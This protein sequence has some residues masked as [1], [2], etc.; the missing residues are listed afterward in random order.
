L[1]L[2]RL[3]PGPLTKRVLGVPWLFAVA[4]SAVGFSLY[5]S[6]GAVADRGLGVT[7]LIF[8][9]AGLLF[10]LATLT[11]VE[12]GAMFGERGGSS[13]LARHAFNELISFIAGW[14]ILID[15]IIVIAL[16]AVSVPHYLSPI[17][18]GFTHGWAE[19]AVAAW[20]ILFTA[21][22]NIAG[23]TGHVRQRPLIALAIAD[24]AVQLAVIAAG[25]I[26]VFQPE[27][28]T[29]NVDLF[30]TPTAR[31]VA[32][33]LAVATLAFAGIEA[34]SDLAP[35]LAWE[36]RDLRRVVSSTALLL[37]LMYAGMAAVALMAVPVVPGP[38]GVHTPLG[39]R[40]IEEPILGVVQSYDPPWLS[41]TLEVAVTAVAPIVLAWAASTSML[42]L[43]RHVYVLA[44]NRQVPSWLGKLG[45]RST[46]YVAISAA[47]L[48]AFAIAVPTD[49]R[50]LAGI[51][52]F[53]AT[54]A[55]AIAHLSLVRLRWT[56]PERPR[57]FRVPF[58]IEVRGRLLPVPAIAGAV[59]MLLLWLTVLTLHGNAR[60]VGGG[61]MVFGLVAYVVYRRFV[62]RTSLTKRVSVPE[63]ALRKRVPE[64]EYG[65]I[66][67]PVFGTKLDDDIVGTAGRLADAADEP[68]EQAPRLKVIYVLDLPLTV[69]LDAPPP[70]QRLREAQAALERAREVAEEYETVEVET[71]LI[72]AR[73]VGAGI[74]EEARKRDVEVIVMGAEPPTR[75]RGGAVLG[76]IGGTRPPE[77]GEVTE[78]VLKKAPCRVLLT[79][80]PEG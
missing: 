14:A 48:V 56:Q 58:E 19:I 9:A 3:G 16:A 22:V 10:V 63:E 80:P 33:A 13:T 55:I 71:A 73:S 45:Q 26:V 40:F 31:Q 64:L 57:P 37:P 66:L 20:V 70:P 5:F 39:E 21:A 27:L 24:I 36:P 29:A 78:Y 52:A 75:M 38:N 15:Y 60:W 34:A 2:V 49:V 51:Y 4:Y 50:L 47:A 35:D 11:Y 72:P 12:G 62:E 61:W 6:I 30:T 44:T 28:L 46:P 17:W 76:G 8:L 59:L 1:P 77:V 69:P 18:G 32:E 79:A 54:L 25:A 7:P 41:T 23:F 65:D 43:S 42:G 67:V 68:G 74:V 53:G